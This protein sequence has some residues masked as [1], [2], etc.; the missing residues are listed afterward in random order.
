MHLSMC[1]ACIIRVTL[2][3][4]P[5]RHPR[6]F[7]GRRF[8]SLGCLAVPEANI[9]SPSLSVQANV[10]RDNRSLLVKASL[11]FFGLLVPPVGSF[12]HRDTPYGRYWLVGGTE[13][14]SWVAAPA[15]CG[16]GYGEAGFRFFTACCR[17]CEFGKRWTSS[18]AVRIVV[19]TCP[20]RSTVPEMPLTLISS[21]SSTP[22]AT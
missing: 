4:F 7:S 19:M 14:L 16:T 15:T 20:M 3:R 2:S 9:A 1:L 22:S 8:G 11:C 6:G 12:G 10:T 18:S 17:N 13:M 5:C 21:P